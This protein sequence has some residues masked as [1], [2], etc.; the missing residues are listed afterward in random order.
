MEPDPQPGL[1]EAE[2]PLALDALELDQLVKAKRHYPR[3]RLRGATVALMWGLRLY[4]LLALAVVGDRIAQ[5]ISG[6]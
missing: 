3:R 1:E 5:A 4:V 6:H 2:E